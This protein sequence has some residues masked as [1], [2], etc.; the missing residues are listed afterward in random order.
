MRVPPVHA[1]GLLEPLS[2]RYLTVI[3]TQVDGQV[4]DALKAG[5]ITEAQ[6]TAIDVALRSAIAQLRST[7]TVPSGL[8][9]NLGSVLNPDTA[10]FLREA[11]R[12]DPAVLGADLPAETP[13]LTSCSND[14]IQV[15][16]GEVAHL[17]AGLRRGRSALDGVHLTGVDH[18]LKVDP[19]RTAVY[20]GDPL[21]FSPA[22]RRAIESFVRRA[23]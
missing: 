4:T 23:L 3:A 5:Q 16:C 18:V 7:G 13:V 10:L 20:Y 9:D 2:E 8:P 6:A 22:L 14:D 19:S 15:S 21:P 11:D 17:D 1:L 12:Y